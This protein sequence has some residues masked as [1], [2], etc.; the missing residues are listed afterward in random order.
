[1][2]RTLGLNSIRNDPATWTYARLLVELG[3]QARAVPTLPIRM[4]IYDRKATLVPIDPTDNGAGAVQLTGAGNVAAVLAPFEQTP[5][6]ATPLHTARITSGDDLS[7]QERKLLK[8]LAAGLT[9]EGAGRQLGLSQ[10]TVRRMMADLME[11]LGARGRFDAG[12]RAAERGRL[13]SERSAT[14]CS[15]LRYTWSNAVDG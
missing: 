14:T 12:R 13:W 1:V 4:L 2:I 7:P 15:L 8:L 11:R 10:R 5:T 9:D 6:T 3:T